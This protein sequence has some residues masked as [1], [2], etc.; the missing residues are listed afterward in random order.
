[1]F[2]AKDLIT[3]EMVEIDSIE[4]LNGEIEYVHFKIGRDLE[5]R[6]KGEDLELYLYGK[7]I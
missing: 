2:T 3:G 1:M 5:S 6:I 4:F 7:K